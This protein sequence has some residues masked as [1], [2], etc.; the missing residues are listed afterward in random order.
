MESRYGCILNRNRLRI[1]VKA[2]RILVFDICY[3]VTQPQKKRQTW[4]FHP[5]S[6]K[7]SSSRLSKVVEKD[8]GTWSGLRVDKFR[9]RDFTNNSAKSHPLQAWPVDKVLEERKPIL[10]QLQPFPSNLI[11]DSISALYRWIN[12]R[13][14][15]LNGTRPRLDDCQWKPPSRRYSPRLIIEETISL[16]MCVY[17]C[18]CNL[19][20]DELNFTIHHWKLNYGGYMDLFNQTIFSTSKWNWNFEAMMIE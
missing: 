3:I 1:F 18:V 11:L 20:I 10:T 14:I 2:A 9:R 7:P 5:S 17:M 12:S 13:Q 8:D 4:N 16:C 19:V 15:V 6:N